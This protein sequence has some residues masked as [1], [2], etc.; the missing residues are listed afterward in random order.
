MDLY[1][2]KSYEHK[3]PWLQLQS[4]SNSITQSLGKPIAKGI[5]NFAQSSEQRPLHQSLILSVRDTPAELL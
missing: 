1:L 4:T 5:D 2:P 3:R